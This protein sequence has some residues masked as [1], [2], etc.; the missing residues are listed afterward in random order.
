[1]AGSGE[2]SVAELFGTENM[3]G[4]EFAKQK[5]ERRANGVKSVVPGGFG[6]DAMHRKDGADAKH[7]GGFEWQA[8]DGV[9]GLA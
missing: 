1:M 3:A 8:E 7:V 9:F 5:E 2:N 6:F 4:K